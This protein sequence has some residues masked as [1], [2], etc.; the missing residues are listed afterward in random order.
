[1]GAVSGAVCAI[2]RYSG[3]RWKTSLITVVALFWA[4][5]AAA[6][7]LTVSSI[8]I[9]GNQRVEAATI[10]SFAEVARGDTLTAGQINEVGQRLRRS[11]LFESV[12]V[13]PAGN[14][15]R[16]TVVEFPTVNQIAVEGND[17]LSDEVL[18][19]LVE[20][21]PRRVFSPSLA[22]EDARRII[23]AYSQSGRI[24]ASVEPRIIRR[25]D[26]RVDLVFEV[27]EGRVV[28]IERIGF[29]GNRAYSDRRLRRVLETKQAGIFR[30]LFRSDTFIADRIAFDRQLLTD[31]Y[32]SRGYV[33]FQILSVTPTLTRERDAFLITFNLREGQ[34]FRVGQVTATSTLGDVDPQEFQDE[35]RMREGMVYTPVAVDNTI[36][37][38]ERLAVAKSLNFIR[39]EPRITR[40]DRERTLDV[41]YVISRGP[42]VFVERIDIEGNTTTLDRVIRREFR[43][44]EGDPFN[45]RE[46]RQAAERIR[47]LGFFSTSTVNAREGSAP[48]RVIVDVDVE[49]QPTGSLSFGA[50]FGAD[51]GLG[52]A[53]GFSERNF[54]GR[55]QSLNVDI[56]TT[57]DDQALQIRFTEP[58]FLG[59]DLRFGVSVFFDESDDSDATFDTESIGFS[60]SLN[61]PV[62]EFSRLSVNYRLSDDNLFGIGE[63]SSAI[64]AAE[65]GSLITSSFGYRYTYDT[66][67]RGLNPNAG[68]LFR[69]SQDLAGFGGD[70]DYL[71]TRALLVGERT[72]LA[73]EVTLRASLDVGALVFFNGNS[74]ATDRFF[75]TSRLVRGFNQ[76]GFG[77]RDLAVDNDDPLGG[78]FFAAVRLET[79]FPIGLPEELGISGGA[80]LDAGSVWGLDNTAGGSDGSSEV[81]DGFILRSSVGLSIFWTTAFGPL[82]FNFSRDLLAEEFDETRSFDLT[83]ST[84][85]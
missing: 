34:Q 7:T 28:E 47:A 42:R 56:N 31:F 20:T 82:R 61:F 23:E 74:R 26:N 63:G 45:P 83:V 51:D 37:R 27:Q 48:N 21:E 44:V 39:V 60:P 36:A 2:I 53:I 71:D 38:L 19:A 43:V 15:L 10:L 55:G 50:S 40:N 5:A 76:N 46:I 68:I 32:Q 72:V 8:Q 41:E 17:S 24:A 9:E 52:F 65:E 75:A 62:G 70:V 54:L 29:V 22:E 84:Q 85:F 11:G 77:P 57:Q 1:M 18:L 80:F 58:F 33:D 67:R 35:I 64:L 73:E 12:E 69:F 6:Q 66:R 79:E 4:A 3:A 25:T 16:I 14:T 13:S 59:R 81:D 30:Q 49:E 78:N